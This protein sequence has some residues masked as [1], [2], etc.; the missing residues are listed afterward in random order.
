[1]GA[2]CGDL[3]PALGSCVAAYAGCGAVGEGE[4]EG[5][6]V[7]D[8]AVV[9]APPEGCVRS[10]SWLHPVELDP[11]GAFGSAESVGAD[12][13]FV[14]PPAV[15]LGPNRTTF[16]AFSHLCI[17][18]GDERGG[19]HLHFDDGPE[20]E[21][22]ALAVEELEVRRVDATSAITEY[23]TGG[24][25][26][27]MLQTLGCDTLT[28]CYLATN[29]GPEAVDQLLLT[30]YHDA[31]LYF[32]GGFTNDTAA[33]ISGPPHQLVQFEDPAP[34]PAPPTALPTVTLTYPPAAHERLVGWEVGE[35]SELR[36]RILDVAPGCVDLRG[37]LFD[38]NGEPIDGDGDGFADHGYDAT[39]ALAFELG[40]LQPGE[41]SGVPVCTI[42]RWK[43]DQVCTGP[44]VCRGVPV[45]DPED[46]DLDGVPDVADLCPQVADPLQRDA[47]GDGVGD[48]CDAGDSD[49]D[50]L[51]D[52]DD[53][54]PLLVEPSEDADADRL[55]DAC[56]PCPAVSQ[57]LRDH[58][59]ADGDGH[60]ACGG[61]CADDDQFR[62]P[63]ADEAP[64][65]NNQ[66]ED[67]DGFVDEGILC[68]P[69]DRP[70]ACGQRCVDLRSD[71]GHCGE[72]GRACEG[73][74]Q[75]VEGDC[76]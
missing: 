24:V 37:G 27:W 31:D 73:A 28:Q 16:E 33:I 46:S 38:G 58:V 47:D 63:G 61:D 25:R 4:G 14:P 35:Y 20:W 23:V 62:F 76:Q 72:C 10:R 74:Q 1:M 12:P 59:D 57:H 69:D 30:R 5:E 68:C 36:S 70:F 6:G 32:L 52:Q 49:G 44:G 51:A 39:A 8:A 22:A 40:P 9:L 50:Q 66:D 67:C 55:G 13:V 54:C 21:G 45:A 29:E 15:E 17:E 43:M 18:R 42:T 56:D 2:G 3:Y 75:C 7:A 26:V 11:L 71:A 48:A 65:C 64:F 41:S 60:F 34:A 19:R 53:P